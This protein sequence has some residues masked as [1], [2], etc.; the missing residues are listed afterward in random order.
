LEEDT[1][2]RSHEALG[3]TSNRGECEYQ[4]HFVS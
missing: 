3:M 4:V 1:A 2:F